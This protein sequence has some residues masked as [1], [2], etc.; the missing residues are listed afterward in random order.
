MA[1][2]KAQHGQTFSGLPLPTPSREHRACRGPPLRSRPQN[3]DPSLRSGFRHAAQL[4][5]C[6]EQ[7]SNANLSNGPRKRLNFES[8]RARHNSRSLA[9]ARDFGCGLP[10]PTPSREHRAC[11]G[12]PLRSHPQN[13]STSQLQSSRHVDSVGCDQLRIRH[14]GTQ[15]D[16]LEP[17]LFF[18]LGEKCQQ[19]LASQPVG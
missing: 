15:L 11:R 3:I 6:P 12:P 5:A 2:R 9:K 13:A 17:S 10:L 8:L 4:L 7:M 14:F 19:V 18:W 16:L 1:Q